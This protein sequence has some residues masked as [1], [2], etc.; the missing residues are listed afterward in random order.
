[1]LAAAGSVWDYVTRLGSVV[2]KKKT[3]VPVTHTFSLNSD[4]VTWDIGQPMF[5]RFE[6]KTDDEK[7]LSSK[8]CLKL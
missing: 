1:M 4:T 8:L 7:V 5:K 3:L 2:V 6:E